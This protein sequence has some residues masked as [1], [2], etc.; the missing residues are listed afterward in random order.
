MEHD[1]GQR[2]EFTTETFYYSAFQLRQGLILVII[3]TQ[4]ILIIGSILLWKFVGL[5]EKS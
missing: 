4:S 1:D 5:S 3:I 2:I